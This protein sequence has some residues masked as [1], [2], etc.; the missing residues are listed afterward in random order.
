MITSLQKSRTRG[1]P[2]VFK[3]VRHGPDGGTA[4]ASGY[5]FVMD[6]HQGQ[7]QCAVGLQPRTPCPASSS[8]R[9]AGDTNESTSTSGTGGCSVISSDQRISANPAPL[10]PRPGCRLSPHPRA[11]LPTARPVPRTVRSVCSRRAA[12][13]AAAHGCSPVRPAATKPTARGLPPDLP[14]GL[15]CLGIQGA[16]G[17]IPWPVRVDDRCRAVSTTVSTVVATTSTGPSGDANAR[18]VLGGCVVSRQHHPG[19]S[20]RGSDCRRCRRHPSRR[21]RDQ[22]SLGRHRRRPRLHQLVEQLRTRTAERRTGEPKL[23]TR[24]GGGEGGEVMA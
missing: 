13:C 10:K 14:R 22:L 8:R 17:C 12:G 9:T 6:Q 23:T 7:T 1:L 21:M 20:L 4:A 11:A 16:L 2:Y 18:R 5:A 15:Q 24:R 3:P 19:L